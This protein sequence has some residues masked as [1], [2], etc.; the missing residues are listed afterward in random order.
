MA[1]NNT[2]K[3]E[4]ESDLVPGASEHR[5]SLQKLLDTA[6]LDDVISAK[7]R[8][9]CVCVSVCV[10]IYSGMYV[11]MYVCMYECMNVRM[12]I[13]MYVCMSQARRQ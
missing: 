12:S 2:K 4:F 11:C 10:C 3:R 13:C 9:V 8:C 5:S 7:R 6:T 1:N